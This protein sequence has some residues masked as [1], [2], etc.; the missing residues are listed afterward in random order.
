[1]F[2]KFLAEIFPVKAV[3]TEATQRN[4]L[5]GDYKIVITP[6]NLSIAE[7]CS[8]GRMGRILFTWPYRHIRRYGCTTENFSFEAGRKCSSGEGLFTFS[9]TDG[10]LI[11]QSVDAHVL[12]LKSSQNELDIPSSPSVNEDK[13]F[14]ASRDSLLNKKES[15]HTTVNKLDQSSSIVHNNDNETLPY[16]NKSTLKSTAPV[17]KPPRK[18][19]SSK[20]A[21]VPTSQSVPH[22]K[23]DLNVYEELFKGGHSDLASDSPHLSDS[24]YNICEEGNISKLNDSAICYS[25]EKLQICDTSKQKD[26]S[27]YNYENCDPFYQS[28]SAD[29]VY[30]KLL[31][32]K[33][34]LSSKDTSSTYGSIISKQNIASENLSSPIYSNVP[35]FQKSCSNIN[36]PNDIQRDPDHFVKND[37]EY[38]QVF[39]KN[40]NSSLF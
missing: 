2:F 20:P 15:I 1:M 32:T 16:Q 5:I 6:V 10:M 35:Y 7:E 14:F 12:A 39:K 26:L 38:A 34:T 37:V 3:L 11:F 31:N 9:T 40:E 24:A 22:T 18:S 13:Y 27:S 28:N 21:Y 8:Q 4:K 29:H 30:G 19:K 23:E 33:Q 36:I 17:S 25:V